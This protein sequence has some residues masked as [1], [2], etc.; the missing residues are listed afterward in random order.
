MDSFDGA[1]FALL[2]DYLG[3]ASR[4]QGEHVGGGR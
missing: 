3:V 2:A 1:K 4:V